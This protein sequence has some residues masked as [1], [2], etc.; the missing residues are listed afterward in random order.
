MQGVVFRHIA[1]NGLS[2]P[3]SVATARISGRYIIGQISTLKANR[4]FLQTFFPKLFIPLAKPLKGPSMNMAGRP[5]NRVITGNFFL[6]LRPVYL[7]SIFSQKS[8][9]PAPKNF[10]SRSVLFQSI[11]LPKSLSRMSLHLT[12]FLGSNFLQQPHNRKL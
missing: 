2:E 7:V 11:L 1:Q 8:H 9:D 4:P 10:I 3:L 6:K 5:S 12:I